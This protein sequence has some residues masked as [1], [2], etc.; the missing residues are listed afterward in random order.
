MTGTRRAAEILGQFWYG[1]CCRLIDAKWIHGIHVRREYQVRCRRLQPSFVDLQR[2]RVIVE[3]FTVSKLSRIDEN[4]DN[5]AFGVFARKFHER[6][7]TR[8]QVPH[9]WDQRHMLIL[10]TP[11]GNPFGEF[12]LTVYDPHGLSRPGS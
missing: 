8:M 6:D 3:V 11:L 7:V 10:L 5:D 12:L 9:R 2:A 4:T 1:H